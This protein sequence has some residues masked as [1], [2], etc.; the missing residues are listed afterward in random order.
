MLQRSTIAVLL[1][2]VALALVQVIDIIL[3]VATNQ[4]EPIRITSNVVILVWLAFAAFGKFKQQGF[5][6]LA[7]GFMGV[8]LAL[9]ITF[10]AVNGLTNAAQGVGLR[11]TLLV[12]IALSVILAVLLTYFWNTRNA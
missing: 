4:V 6:L 3:H 1:I 8:Y 9:N 2:G 7:V 10:L 5:R 11:V 12:L